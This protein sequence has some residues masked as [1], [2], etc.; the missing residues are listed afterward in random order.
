MGIGVLGPL[1]VDGSGDLGRRDRVVLTALA[2]D[3]GHPVSADQLFDALWGE[4]APAS[5]GKIVQGCVVRLRKLLGRDVVRTSAQ[6]YALHL[7]VEEVDS[8][9]FEDQVGRAQELLTLGEADR[10]A[11][12]LSDA[13]ALWRGEPFADLESWEPAVAAGTRLSEL[14]L[15]AEELRIEALLRAGRYR[16]ILSEAQS[17][18]RAAPLREYRWVLLARAQY[19]SGQQAEALRTIHQLRAVLAENLG[20]DPGPEVVALETSILRQDA[21]L[22]VADAPTPSGTCPWLGLRAYGVEDAEWFFGRD[23][24]V[25]ACLEIVART[26]V[27]ALV[28]PSGS[29]KSSLLRA[30]VAAALRGRGQPSV[31]ITPGPHP[32]DSLTALTQAPRGAA[33]LIDQCEELFS[34]CH[35]TEERERFLGVVAA[36]A[37]DRTVAL[38]LRADHLADL[39]A[40]PG[41]SRLVER[42]M[43]LV[44]GLEEDGL[45]SAIETPAR[46]AGLLI[47]PGLVDLLVREVGNDPGALPLMSHALQET[48][49]RREGNTLTVAGYRASGGING[50]VAQSAEGLYS[51]I[52]VER[53][54]LLRDLVLRLVSPGPEGEPVRTRVPRRLVGTDPEHDQLIEMLVT[55]RL[56]TTDD[57]ALEITHE[58]LTRAWPRLRGWLEDDIEGQRIRHHLSTAA[59]SWEA[60]GR[61]DSELYRG[62]RLARALEWRTGENTTLTEIEHAFLQASA[63]HAEDE[64]RSIHERARAQTRLIRRLRIA[65][66]SGAALLVIALVAGALAVVQS[67]RATENAARAEHAA[68]AADAGRVGARALLADDVTLSLLLAAAGAR[69][70]DSPETRANLV[71]ALAMRPELVR[72][73]PAEGDYVE[74]LDVSR[75]GRWMATSD[76]QNRVHLYEAAT[77]RLVDTYDPVQPSGAGWMLAAFSPDGKHLA[78]IP[79]GQGSRDPVRLLDT[80]TMEPTTKLAFPGGRKVWGV[81]VRFSAGGR[82]LAGSVYP[83]DWPTAPEW[84]DEGYTLV[85]DLRAPAKAP[86][87]MPTG[88]V[89]SGAGLSRDGRILYSDWPLAAYDVA[90]GERIWQREEIRSYASSDLNPE[91]TLLALT[92]TGEANMRERSERS[93]N[94]LLVRASDGTTVRTLRGHQDQVR[95]VGFS[96]DGSLVVS[97]SSDGELIA[98]ETATGRLLARWESTSEWGVDFSPDGDLVYEGGGPS[99]VRTWDLSG[100]DTYLRRT[101]RVGDAEVYA[102]ADLS[103]DGRRVAYSWTDGDTG[104]VRFVD[105]ATG[106]AT[107]PARVPVIAGPWGS[108]TWHPEGER[109]V[110]TCVTG[111]C[112]E[113]VVL[114]PAI[115]TVERREV[116]EDDIISLAYVDQGRSLLVG[117]MAGTVVVDAETLQPRDDPF[118]FPAS[119]IVP[120][121]DGSSAMVGGVSADGLSEQWQVIDVRTGDVRTEGSLDIARYA[122]AASP[123]GS[124]VAVAGETGEIVATDVSTGETLQR[125]TGPGAAVLGLDYSDDG[126]LLVSAADDGRVSLWDATTLDPL[127]T[128]RPPHEGDPVPADAQFIGDSHDVAIASNDGTVHRWETGIDRAVEFACRMAGRDLTEQEWDEFL[129]EEPYRPVCPDE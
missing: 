101:S 69:L 119:T 115:G 21:S 25:A 97:H 125:S 108:G 28:G 74:T 65:L 30:G 7:P 26:S 6:G 19:Q 71:A 93:W 128:V 36:E 104:W 50:A 100:Q 77:G 122:S 57:D 15:E 79:N 23:P 94:V 44:G 109:Y 102:H 51:R 47:E 75:D 1:T 95:D 63:H 41:F 85:W 123:D 106:K 37:A 55:A 72:S 42:G 68:V 35:D 92:D 121:G 29:G 2:T 34:L 105:T 10:A 124:T 99:M 14:R 103:P 24:D 59:D 45:R 107:P 48:W 62:V 22:L 16:E 12:L 116:L 3:P 53:R 110:A 58:A 87:R 126:K 83:S 9:R 60:L 81:D 56:V 27:L 73:A 17:L 111:E 49:K 52:E 38:A 40:Y 91:G 90:S 120:I 129:P 118:E 117:G 84:E 113:A 4:G 80:S 66:A 31:T 32:M 76:G 112:G 5:A 78:V 20:I 86:V 61:P 43:Y 18:V 82:Y 96:P 11:Y 98:W 33:L 46:Q 67:D 114:D 39:A 13:L 70:D 64:Q 54:H 88:T 89:P 127:G 8:L